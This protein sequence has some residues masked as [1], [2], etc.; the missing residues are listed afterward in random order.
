MKLTTFIKPLS[1][2]RMSGAKPYA[3]VYTFMTRRVYLYLYLKVQG[4]RRDFSENK[5][6]HKLSNYIL[7]GRNSELGF[8]E[9]R[10]KLGQRCEGFNPQSKRTNRSVLLLQLYGNFPGKV[11]G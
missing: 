2:S 5:T 1:R 4:N 11:Q 9:H 6:I 3:R 7:R 10:L 8:D